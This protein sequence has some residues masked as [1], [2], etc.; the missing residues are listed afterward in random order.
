M[1]VLHTYVCPFYTAKSS[2]ESVCLNVPCNMSKTVT[3]NDNPPRQ[4]EEKLS[5]VVLPNKMK[6]GH[7]INICFLEKLKNMQTDHLS[8][9]VCMISIL[10]NFNFS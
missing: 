9:H 3:G 4:Q 10:I 1:S 2:K 6:T 5:H 8:S 7:K